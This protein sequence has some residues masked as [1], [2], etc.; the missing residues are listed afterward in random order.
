MK[1][2]P[3][4]NPSHRIRSISTGW[5][6]KGNQSFL[7]W[8]SAPDPGIF[9][10]IALAFDDTAK[11]QC[12]DPYDGTGASTERHRRAIDLAIPRRVA[13][14]QSPTPFRQTDDTLP[15]SNEERKTL[16]NKKLCGCTSGEGITY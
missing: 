1:R 6:E 15:S 12:P 16:R 7:D 8:G 11:Q 5:T 9:P 4:P 3:R 2:R 10:G 14:P 13:S